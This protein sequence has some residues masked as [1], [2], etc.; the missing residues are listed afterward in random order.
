LLPNISRQAAEITVNRIG[1]AIVI[2]LRP[3][4]NRRRAAWREADI[5]LQRTRFGQNGQLH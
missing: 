5:E 2:R 3:P 1:D 4:A